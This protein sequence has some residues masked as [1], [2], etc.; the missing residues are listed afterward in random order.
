MVLLGGC[1]DVLGV[2]RCLLTRQV[3]AQLSKS[4]SFRLNTGYKVLQEY[5]VMR[6]Q[7]RLTTNTLLS[8]LGLVE[9]ILDVVVVSHSEKPTQ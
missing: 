5:C 2:A 6:I 7:I 8:S 1:Y 9:Q 4:H 3:S